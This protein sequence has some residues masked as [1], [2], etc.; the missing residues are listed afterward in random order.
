MIGELKISVIIPVYQAEKYLDECVQSVRC[1]TYENLEIILVDDGSRD[2]SPRMCDEYAASDPRIRVIHKENG[3]L[4]SARNAG[5]AVAE[6]DYILF[7]DS[8][9]FWNDSEAIS[10][11]ADRIGKTEAQVLNFSYVKYFED[12]GEMQPY[13]KNIPSMPEAIKDRRGQWS[14]LFGRG[15][16]IASACNKLIRRSLLTD[17]LKFRPGVYS[18]DIEWCLRL[19]CKAESMDFICE[20]FYCYRQRRDSITHTIDDKKCRDLC[21][22]ILHCFRICEE[23]P[24]DIRQEL[25]RYLAYQFGTF[26]MVQAK[27]E[28]FQTECIRELIP[29]ARVLKHHGKNR[30]LL[31]LR[32]ATVILGMPNTCKLIRWLYRR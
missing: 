6:G 30:K 24:E 5:V 4:S 14:Y 7:L 3:G 2:S 25:Y 1:Q 26:F 27:A 9:D 17:D 10:S 16:C 32:T 20:N 31:G 15:L 19:F 22:N 12:T 13:F 11:L 29:Y 28:N 8:D 23:A 18:E 21:D